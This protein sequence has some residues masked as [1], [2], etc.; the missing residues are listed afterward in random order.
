M[1]ERCGVLSL[2]GD[3]EWPQREAI[4]APVCIPCETKKE[5]PLGVEILSWIPG[6]EELW[7]GWSQQG[8]WGKTE[9][10]LQCQ[11]TVQWGV[12][13]RTQQHTPKTGCL[14][15][16]S[17]PRAQRARCVN[18]SSSTD[19]QRPPVSMPD[20]ETGTLSFSHQ[21]SQ[22]TE[23]NRR[24]GYDDWWHSHLTPPNYHSETQFWKERLL[25]QT[26]GCIFVSK[27]DRAFNTG[28]RHI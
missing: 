3:I 11:R 21:R 17:T 6:Q 26:C 14:W 22:N 24:K 19:H 18:W 7:G 1:N 10:G 15:V 13:Q 12:P 4:P 23:Q 5:L 25:N 16:F 9:P 8:W 20:E 28:M 27:H 2:C